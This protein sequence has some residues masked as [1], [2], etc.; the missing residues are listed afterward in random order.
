MDVVSKFWK[1]VE[2]AVNICF[3]RQATIKICFHFAQFEQIVR[4]EN[5]LVWTMVSLLLLIAVFAHQSRN[6]KSDMVGNKK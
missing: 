4:W 2:L 6:L 1:S 3:G 5:D